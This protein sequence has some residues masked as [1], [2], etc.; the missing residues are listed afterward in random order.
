MVLQW[1]RC[2]HWLQARGDC[3]VGDV[4]SVYTKFIYKDRTQELIRCIYFVALECLSY[5]TSVCWDLMTY[6]CLA[7][8]QRSW[9]GVCI[10]ILQ[11]HKQKLLCLGF[12]AGMKTL[13]C[14]FTSPCCISLSHGEINIELHRIEQNISLIDL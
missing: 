10:I 8:K 3:R 12:H 13:Q 2:C 5:Q 11:A 1:R 7:I 9:L 14:S 6:L 4:V